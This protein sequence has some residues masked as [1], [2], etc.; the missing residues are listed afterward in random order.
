M[1]FCVKWYLFSS[2]ITIISNLEYLKSFNVHKDNARAESE[3]IY[4]CNRECVIFSHPS[5]GTLKDAR[6][7]R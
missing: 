6:A 5:G 4:I 3:C 1:I 7:V 2:T